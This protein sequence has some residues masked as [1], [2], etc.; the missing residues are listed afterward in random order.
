M[1][2]SELWRPSS[3]AVVDSSI[4]RL[5]LTR[6]SDPPCVFS[7]VQLW[8]LSDDANASRGLTKSRDTVFV[9]SASSPQSCLPDRRQTKVLGRS[10]MNL[11]LSSGWKT[12]YKLPRLLK[13]A[14]SP[15][16][17]PVD[18]KLRAPSFPPDNEWI[19]WITL[20]MLSSNVEASPGDWAD[21]LCINLGCE[22]T[23]FKLHMIPA[24]IKQNQRLPY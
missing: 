13:Y 17:S 23:C 5:A 2:V 4:L 21:F 1:F 11:P 9:S 19:W 15:E 6:W 18:E 8:D 7:G 14:F 10:S 16:P 20:W 3:T 12:M 24:E 22:Y